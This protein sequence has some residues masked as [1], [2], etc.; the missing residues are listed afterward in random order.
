M[1]PKTCFTQ[2]Q[3]GCFPSLSS[4]SECRYEW[5]ELRS[6]KENPLN[7]DQWRKRCPAPSLPTGPTILSL[8]KT[9]DSHVHIFFLLPASIPVSSAH[10]TGSTNSEGQ[11]ARKEIQNTRAHPGGVSDAWCVVSHRQGPGAPAPTW[12]KASRPQYVGMAISDRCQH[13]ASALYPLFLPQPSSLPL[14][15]NAI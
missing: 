10:Q 9:P 13:G 11:Q 3:V 2:Y 8:N 15:Q 12:N 14:N 4:S 6:M 5:A 1:N 7:L